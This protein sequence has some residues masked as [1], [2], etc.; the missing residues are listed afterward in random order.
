MNDQQFTLFPQPSPALPEGFDYRSDVI[1][2]DEESYL[3][4]KVERLPFKEFQF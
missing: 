1:S 4:A 3:L 2:R